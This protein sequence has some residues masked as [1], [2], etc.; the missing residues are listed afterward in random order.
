ME[1]E[2][3]ILQLLA[4]EGRRRVARIVETRQVTAE[5]ALVI[6]VLNLN[7]ELTNTRRG[8]EME[9]TNTRRGFQA[10]I[11]RTR[12]ELSKRIEDLDNRISKR[13]DD[14]G[15]YFGKRV[16]DL[17]HAMKVTWAMLAVLMAMQAA[18]IA[19]LLRL[20]IP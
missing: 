17:W 3:L 13:I 4:E 9:L 15:S 1:E 19:I 11:S 16:D 8:F 20:L 2:G 5:D 12:E 18:T 6:G 14:L 7:K 10:E